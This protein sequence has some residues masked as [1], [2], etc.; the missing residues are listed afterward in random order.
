[1]P[2]TRLHPDHFLHIMLQELGFVVPYPSRR[3]EIS[4]DRLEEF[5]QSAV[6]PVAGASPFQIELGPVNAFEDAIFLEIGGGAR[7][8]KL[9]NRLFEL[10]AIP[11]EPDFPYLPHCTLAHFTGVSSTAGAVAALTP[12]RSVSFG[13]L[14]VTEVEIVTMNAAES[15]PILES[16]AVIPLGR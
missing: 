8:S 3:D 10:A 16:Y 2:E 14:E 5:A 12:F 4:A 7:L 9:H 6:E 11:S 1:M 15:Y 13:A